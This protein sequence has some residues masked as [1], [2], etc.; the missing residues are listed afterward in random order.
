MRAKALHS[1]STF[2]MLAPRVLCPLSYS[3]QKCLIF[4]RL[5]RC[6]LFTYTCFIYLCCNSKICKFI[7][8]LAQFFVSFHD[9]L[10]VLGSP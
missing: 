2:A 4:E 6:G 10:F 5:A 9:T 1:S 8:T 7:C 3:V